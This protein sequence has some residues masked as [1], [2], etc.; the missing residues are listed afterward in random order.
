MRQIQH[1]PPVAGI[2]TAQRLI[3]RIRPVCSRCRIGLHTGPER[4]LQNDELRDQ[5]LVALYAVHLQLLPPNEHGHIGG[6]L[7]GDGQLVHDLQL[8]VFGH[9]VFP[10]PGAIDACGLALQDLDIG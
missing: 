1:L 3:G 8:N 9:T 10:E 6:L 4:L 2:Q 7:A 5:G